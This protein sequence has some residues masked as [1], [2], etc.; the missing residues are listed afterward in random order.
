MQAVLSFIF[1]VVMSCTV[2]AQTSQPGLLDWFQGIWLDEVSGEKYHW[3]KTG[4]NELRCR[5]YLPEKGTEE[6]L[7][8][9]VLHYTAEGSIFEIRTGTQSEKIVSTELLRDLAHFKNNETEIK[10]QRTGTDS[11]KLLLER[12]ALSEKKEIHLKRIQR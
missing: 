11:M 4:I 8:H 6:E 7:Y 1:L 3:T 5:V 12:K 2:S 9:Y 10:F